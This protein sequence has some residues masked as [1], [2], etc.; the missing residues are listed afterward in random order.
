M[1]FDDVTDL[2]GNA[3][4]LTRDEIVDFLKKKNDSTL[5]DKVASLFNKYQAE[6]L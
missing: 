6:A 5:K 2:Y 3:V 1:K 4:T